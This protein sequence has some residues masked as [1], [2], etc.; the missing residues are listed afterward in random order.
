M[1]LLLN[2]LL[3]Q[4]VSNWDKMQEHRKF[5][6]AETAV[7]TPAPAELLPTPVPTELVVEK[8]NE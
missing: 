4:A 1:D 6:E 7:V 2:L 3:D 8:S 5:K